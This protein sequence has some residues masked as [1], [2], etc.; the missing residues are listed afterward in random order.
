MAK[1]L[2]NAV[3]PEGGAESA[4]TIVDVPG[5]YLIDAPAPKTIAAMQ[6][7]G[8]DVGRY[9]RRQ[10]TQDMLDNYDRVIVMAEPENT[11]DWLRDNPKATRWEIEDTRGM[12][13][14][15]TRAKRDELRRR[16]ADL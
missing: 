16:I 4:G 9:T 13:L 8:I 15:A 12:D 10:L 2:Y 6:E 7:L 11:P 3:H 5:Q 1:A 14:A